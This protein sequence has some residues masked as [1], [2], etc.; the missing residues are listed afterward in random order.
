LKILPALSELSWCQNK[1]DTPS[2]WEGSNG[3]HDLSDA[4]EHI[5][6]HVQRL[7]SPHKLRTFDLSQVGLPDSVNNTVDVHR[8]HQQHVNHSRH[9][10]EER[11]GLPATTCKVV[12]TSV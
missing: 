8:R 3:F 5:P 11:E 1:D 9:E 12:K 10:Q 4:Q 6:E 2:I 7:L